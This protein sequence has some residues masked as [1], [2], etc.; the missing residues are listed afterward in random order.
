MRPPELAKPLFDHR[1]VGQNPTVDGRMALLARHLEVFLQPILD[2]RGKLDLLEARIVGS[3]LC[4]R[5]GV[6]ANYGRRLIV[7]RVTDANS[8]RL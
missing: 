6:R 5:E 4:H 1:R 3:P 8:S 2:R 7:L